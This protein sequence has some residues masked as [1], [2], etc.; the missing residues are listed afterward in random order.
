[1]DQFRLDSLDVFAAIVR[2]GGF[3]AAALERG[4]SSSA[5]S[6]TIN[7]LEEALGIRLLNRTTRSVSPTEGDSI[8]CS[9]SVQL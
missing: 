7:A 2:C 3:R 6:Q 1:M 9:A 5:L 8:F 4:V